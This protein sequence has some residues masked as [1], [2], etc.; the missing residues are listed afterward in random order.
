MEPD[1]Q[2]SGASISPSMVFVIVGSGLAALVLIWIGYAYSFD[3]LGFSPLA[4]I[5]VFF[6]FLVVSIVG[7]GATEATPNDFRNIQDWLQWKSLG[8]AVYVIIM[9]ALG[10]GALVSSLGTDLNRDE[11]VALQSKV[12]ET[13]A[14][15]GKISK[16]LE[17]A[18]FGAVGNGVALAAAS[19]VWGERGCDVTYDIAIEGT[20]LTMRSLK[21]PLGVPPF[22]QTLRLSPVRVLGPGRLE[23]SGE[24]LAGPGESK[25]VRFNYESVGS[26]ELLTRY[27]G[28]PVRQTTFDRCS[29]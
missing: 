2:S 25:N 6:V 1:D 9:G 13:A 21:D 16:Q 27:E 14:E 18:G 8:S 19:G 20:A 23:V 12:E 15:T 29:K 17:N 5:S 11:F 28:N 4:V 10:V 7:L 24:V 3:V 22:E 26:V